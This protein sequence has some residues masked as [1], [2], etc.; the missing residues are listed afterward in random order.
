MSTDNEWIK[1]YIYNRQLVIKKKSYHLQ[2]HG[3]RVYYTKLNK[4]DRERQILYD[5]TDMQSLKK[6][7]SEQAKQKQAQ[8]QRTNWLPEG[9]RVERWEK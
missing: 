3:P 7:K 4:S 8:I 2:Q 1:W 6:Q 5:I 9:K